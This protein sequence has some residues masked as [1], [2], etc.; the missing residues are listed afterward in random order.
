MVKG[1]NSSNINH[2]NLYNRQSKVK[3]VSFQGQT[4]QNTTVLPSQVTTDFNVQV[5][6]AYTKLGVEKM[7]NGQEVHCYKLSNGQR[8]MIAPMKS[9]KTYVNTYVNTGAMNEKDDERGISHFTEHMAFNGTSGTD[10][11]MKLG[12]GDVFAKVAEMGGETNASTGMAETNYTIGIPQF[13]KDDLETAVAMQASMMNNLEMSDAMVDKEHGPVC[14]EINM[15]SD[16]MP[17]KA[18][19]IAKKNLYNISSTSEDLIAGRVDN[20]KNI[21]RKKVT[22]Y[23][24]NNYYPANMTTVITG[25]VEPEEAVKLIAKYFKG[26]NKPNLDRR[27]EK[28]TPINKTVRK[29]VISDKAVSTNSTICFNGPANNNIK[30]QAAID[31]AMSLLFLKS[32][33][34]IATPLKDINAE[35]SPNCERVSTVPTDGIAITFDI[36]T[37]EANSE[38]ALKRVFTELN[39]FKVKDENEL[40]QVKTSIKSKYQDRYEDPDRLNYMIGSG[41][42]SY[43]ISDI[44]NQ[45]KIIDSLTIKDVEDAVHKYMDTSK[46]SIAV[47]HP[48]TVTSESL[49]MNYDKVN[50]S[51]VSFKGNVN[52]SLPIDESKISNYKLNN[53]YDI[54]FY[55]TPQNSNAKANIIY[56]PKNPIEG[57]PGVEILLTRMLKDK[58]ANKDVDVFGDYLDRNNLSQSI[59]VKQGGKIEINGKMPANNIQNFINITQE[60]LMMPNFDE[61]TFNKQKNIVKEILAHSEPDAKEGLYKAMYP[62]STFGYTTKDILDN[63]DNVSLKDVKDYYSQIMA[64]SSATVTVAAPMADRK[65]QNSVLNSF[66]KMPNVQPNQPK[67]FELHKPMEK[68]QVVTKEAPHSQAEIIQAYNFKE[69]GNIKDNVTFALMNGILSKGKTTGLFNNLREKEKLAYAVNS[70]YTGDGDNSYVVCNILTT[71]DNKDTGEHTYDNVQKS[72]NGF[73]NQINKMKNGE[74]TDKELEIV[75]KE[76]KDELRTSAYGQKH[77]AQIVS[78][79]QNSPYGTNRANEKYKAID[80]ITREDI[81]KAAQYVFGGKPVYSI[82]ASKDTLDANKEFLAGLENS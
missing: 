7:A 16:F 21:D 61:A 30:E 19:N 50:N 56:T 74:F 37:P 52:H 45:E 34:R 81:Q 10:G 43:G 33:S 70:V 39:N 62:N 49:K 80:S 3:D 13:D 64:N 71:T 42:L 24:K 28:L 78:S 57:K 2:I 14:S 47:V 66:A 1:L 68:S 20:I 18:N 44:A 65:V 55:D 69:T 38:K 46:A 32:N 59:S 17:E 31:V 82:V 73:T 22:D 53:N 15:Y 6:Q 25:D 23:Y 51:Q 48:A 60:Q 11:Y 79:G 58:T 35:I 75:K 9:P 54:A 5:P 77:I 26:E 76:F 40:E 4:A 41:S 63:I 67:L 27:F 8:V 12:V 36:D 29:D 72:I